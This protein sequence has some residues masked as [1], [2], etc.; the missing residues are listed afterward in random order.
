MKLYNKIISGG[1]ILLMLMG[2]GCSDSNDWEP[3]EQD[4]AEGVVA[5]FEV[6]AESMY[7]FDS[8]TD[9]GTWTIPVT[10]KRQKTTEAAQVPISMTGTVEGFSIPATVNF[11]AGA[12]EAVFNIVCKDLPLAK[13]GEVTVTIDPSQSSIYGIGLD[14]I[15]FKAIVSK[16][17]LISDDVTYYYWRNKGQTEKLYPNT[18][19]NMYHLEGTMRFKLED[20][21]GSGLD[22]MFESSATK[23]GVSEKLLPLNNCV[24]YTEYEDV[25]DDYDCWDLYDD[26]IDDYPVFVPGNVEG[27][28]EIYYLTFYGINDDGSAYTYFSMISNVNKL[29]GW[30]NAMALLEYADESTAWGYWQ[31]SWH[32]KYNPFE[33]NEGGAE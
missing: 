4:P 10:M 29:Y 15:S 23:A 21:F 6:P 32:L 26:A 9:S 12:S 25:E 3:G 7:V 13:L 14:A 31:W 33:N 20:F 28:K 1:T 30:G 27:G 24:Y 19:S 8:A 11:E 5:Y 17:A 2:G 16:W 22:I 18:K